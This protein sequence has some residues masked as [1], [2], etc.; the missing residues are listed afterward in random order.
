MIQ[1]NGLKTNQIQALLGITQ[2]YQV[3]ENHE[4]QKHVLPVS[5]EIVEIVKKT[6]NEERR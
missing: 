5:E 6:L 1:I 4:V 2:K 3:L